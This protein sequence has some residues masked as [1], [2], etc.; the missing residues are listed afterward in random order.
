MALPKNCECLQE[1]A[2]SRAIYSGQYGKRGQADIEVPTGL[3]VFQM[4]VSKQLVPHSKF[5]RLSR[6]SYSLNFLSP[7]RRE[8]IL[9]SHGRSQM[10][11][12]TFQ[13]QYLIFEPI[14]QGL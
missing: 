11:D 5:P 7:L 12:E 10:L 13:L 8:E 4:N 2:L 1:G 14:A 6:F 3:E 9:Q